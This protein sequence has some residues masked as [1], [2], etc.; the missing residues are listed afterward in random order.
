MCHCSRLHPVLCCGCTCL[1]AIG[2]NIPAAAAAAA[3]AASCCI[4]FAVRIVRTNVAN[5]VR[6]ISIV[7]A[8]AEATFASNPYQASFMDLVKG[9]SS[10]SNQPCHTKDSI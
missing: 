1:A 2:L 3:A 10:R 4:G 6:N 7:P 9:A 8:T 5:P